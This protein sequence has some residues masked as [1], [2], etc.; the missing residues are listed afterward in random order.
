MDDKRT[1]EHFVATDQT[2]D[3]KESVQKATEAAA[4]Q[5]AFW[6]EFYKVWLPG[7][8]AKRHR[9]RTKGHGLRR[10]ERRRKNKAAKV[11]RRANRRPKKRRSK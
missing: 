3:F 6:R 5:V 1:N 4:A 2:S 10:A 8:F 9:F 11:A 7:G